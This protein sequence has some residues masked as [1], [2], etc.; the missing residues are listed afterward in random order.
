MKSSIFW[1]INL[2]SP[3]WKSTDNLEFHVTC[4]FKVEQKSKPGSV[5]C[6]LHSVSSLDYFPNLTWRRYTSPKCRSYFKMHGV[7]CQNVRRNS[8]RN[9]ATWYRLNSPFHNALFIAHN[10]PKHHSLFVEPMRISVKM[11]LS[12]TDSVLGQTILV[13]GCSYS[14]ETFKF[15]VC[16]L[17]S[18]QHET[19]ICMSWRDFLS[20]ERIFFT[21]S[22]VCLLN[23]AS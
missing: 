2:C 5:R 17:A 15:M 13:H 7:I 21:S 1:H 12:R 9:V 14:S 4:D 18:F 19:R 3:L 8:I 6:L 10:C 16:S 11:H 20:W 23:R 22:T